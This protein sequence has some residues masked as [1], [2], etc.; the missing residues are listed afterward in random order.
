MIDSLIISSNFQDTFRLYF[1]MTYAKNGDLLR[2]IKQLPAKEV[3][4]P[5]EIVRFYSAEILSAVEFMH[6]KGIIHRDLKP[7][8]IL[9][10]DRLHIL[11]SQ[12]LFSHQPFCIILEK[13]S[14]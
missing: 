10:S 1:V 7:E 14:A 4:N 12:T 9:L 3:A 11:V 2:L 6:E 5:I 8:N 13:S